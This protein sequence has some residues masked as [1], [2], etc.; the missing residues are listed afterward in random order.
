[1][2]C[3]VSPVAMFFPVTATAIWQFGQASHEPEQF[4]V[5]NFAGLAKLPDVKRSVCGGEG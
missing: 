3:D 2:A 1:M 4:R 5:Q